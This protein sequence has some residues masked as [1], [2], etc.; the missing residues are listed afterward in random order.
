[1]NENTAKKINESFQLNKTF[2]EA[3]KSYFEKLS[4]LTENQNTINYEIDDYCD[5]DIIMNTLNRKAYISEHAQRYNDLL[6]VWDIIEEHEKEVE[7]QLTVYTS[8]ADVLENLYKPLTQIIL[9]KMLKPIISKNGKVYDRCFSFALDCIVKPQQNKETIEDIEQT[10]AMVI[11]ACHKGI[12]PTS[13]FAKGGINKTDDCE[14]IEKD[15]CKYIY[16]NEYNEFSYGY[17]INTETLKYCFRAVSSIANRY[18]Q[19]KMKTEWQDIT[20]TDENGNSIE[21][22]VSIK[23]PIYNKTICENASANTTFWIKTIQAYILKELKNNGEKPKK[24]VQ[25]N[26]V[27]IGLKRGYTLTEIAKHLKLS[28]QTV[29]SCRDLMF[30]TLNK[31]KLENLVKTTLQTTEKPQRTNETWFTNNYPSYNMDITC[32]NRQFDN[33]M[34]DA[35]KQE[36]QEDA[37]QK[38]WNNHKVSIDTIEKLLFG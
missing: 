33:N 31:D 32:N 16:L 8:V 15:T 26:K 11:V 37:R 20:F 7:K 18:K 10:L 29:A 9:H 30:A 25:C 21:S 22:Q 36:M 5:S 13:L 17:W 1:M 3:N 2:M 6:S 27:F 4:A 24:I 19:E 34:T 38:Y 12:N 23:N 35:Q 14:T 28:R